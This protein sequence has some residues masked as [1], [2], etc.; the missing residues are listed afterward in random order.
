VALDRLDEAVSTLRDAIE[1]ARTRQGRTLLW[2]CLLALGRAEQ[3]RGQRAE[4][5]RAFAEARVV[6]AEIAVTLPDGPIAEYGLTSARD[7]FLAATT[8]LFPVTRQPT[9]LQAA[10]QAFGGLTARERDVAA[11]IARGRSNRAIAADLIVG[12]RTVAT[13]VAAILAKLDFTSRS[14]IAAWA[15]ESGL[16]GKTL[17]E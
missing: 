1:E 14:Q 13:H 5:D 3:Q 10:K 15:V 4:A 6:L 2:Q 8:A 12:E 11:L 7:H 17:N 9:A 16:T